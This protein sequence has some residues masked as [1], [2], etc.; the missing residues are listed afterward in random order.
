MEPFVRR[1]PDWPF[2]RLPGLWPDDDVLLVEE[3]RE[4]G[5]LV[6]RA[7]LPGI[8]P[9]KDVDIEVVDGT[10]RV[11]A[12]RRQE[13]K[14]EEK[15]YVRTELR[16][17]SFARTLPLPA[18]ASEKDVVATYKDGVLEIRI[19]FATPAVPEAKKISIARS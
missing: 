6:I 17:G 5:S 12:E 13:E 10:L 18:G 1:F 9:D 7:D 15:D 3:Y 19:P 16:Y 14:V 2:L 8:D 11:S 4:N